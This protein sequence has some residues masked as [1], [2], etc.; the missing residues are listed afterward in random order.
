[1]AATAA[2]ERVLTKEVVIDAELEAVWRAWTTEAGLAVVSEKSRIELRP[3]GDYA[4]F[5][6]LPADHHGKRGSEG[7]TIVSVDPMHQ[8]VFDWNFPPDIPEL[9]DAGTTTRVSVTFTP[10]DNGVEVQLVARGW[11]GGEVWDRGFAY[12]DRAWGIVLQRMRT[13]LGSEAE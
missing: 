2:S 10:G 9:R 8:L 12:F 1:M 3:G 13:V 6:D 5:L 4:W 11:E 7:S